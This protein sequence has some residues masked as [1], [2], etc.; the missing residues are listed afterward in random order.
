MVPTMP[1]GAAIK[2]RRAQ[3]HLQ[4]LQ[5]L[6][7]EYLESKPFELAENVEPGTGD[8]VISVSSARQPDPE[9]SAVIGDVIHNARSALDQLTWSLVERDGGTPGRRTYFPTG[10]TKSKF[11]KSVKEALDEAA[12][13]TR[14]RVRAL[15][16]H[17]GGDEKLWLLH[18]LDV[19]DKHRLL[20]PVGMAYGA[21]NLHAVLPGFDGGDPIEAPPIA[22]RPADRMYPLQT[23][24]EILRVSKAALDSEGEFATKYSFRFDLV[25]GGGSLI[26]DGQL[27]VATLTDIVAHAEQ[28]AL[29]LV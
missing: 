9:I 7:T 21:F 1:S 3:R 4:E 12:V 2:F 22:I 5:R 6:A 16:V 11:A 23:G 28:T 18:Q 26:A 25:F 20:I 27:V 13:S 8:K 15:A 19:E 24:D 10:E 17:P 29:T 14:D